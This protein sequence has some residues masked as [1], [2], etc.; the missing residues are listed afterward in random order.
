M[1][2]INS[3]VLVAR[4]NALRLGQRAL[5]FLRQLVQIHSHSFVV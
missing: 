2:D 5:G 3:L 4:G 1:L